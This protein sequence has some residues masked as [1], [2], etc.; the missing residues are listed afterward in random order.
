MSGA[1]GLS[2]KAFLSASPSP[3]KEDESDQS[4]G[5]KPDRRG[6]VGC[7]RVGVG[8]GTCRPRS[9]ECRVIQG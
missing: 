4:D 9:P 2:A 6:D 3:T 1:L 5:W 7:C 8:D